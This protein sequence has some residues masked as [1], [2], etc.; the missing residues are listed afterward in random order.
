M[1]NHFRLALAPDAKRTMKGFRVNKPSLAASR[2]RLKVKDVSEMLGG[3]GEV[4]HTA[5]RTLPGTLGNQHTWY[6]GREVGWLQVRL[7]DNAAAVCTGAGRR[8]AN[9]AS[10]AT[11][12]ALMGAAGSG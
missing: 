5:V 4:S 2:A 7:T 3:N 11:A 10:S 6:G 9:T 8:N 1:W 12:G